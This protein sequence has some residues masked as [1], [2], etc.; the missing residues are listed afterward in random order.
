[1]DQDPI[2]GER[3]IPYLCEGTVVNRNDP[4]GLGRVTVRIEGLFDETAWAWPKGSGSR[5]WGRNVVPPAGALVNVQFL[6]GHPRLPV[7][8][9]GRIVRPRDGDNRFP[10]F[11]DPDVAVF[12]IGPFRVVINNRAGQERATFSAI[13]TVDGVEEH[14]VELAVDM[15]NKTNA[16]RLFATT[17]LLLETLGVLDIKGNQT[18]VQDRVVTPSG[19]A[20][21]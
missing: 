10:E 16:V 5:R 8:E 3:L 19:K 15:T 11:E 12:G 18:Q 14:T 13:R 6:G 9:P 1:M 2:S 21:N 20:L 7:Y 17:A 4:E